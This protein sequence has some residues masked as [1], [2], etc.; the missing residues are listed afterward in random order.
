MTRLT[1]VLAAAFAAAL[2]VGCERAELSGPPELKLGRHECA[3]CGM[4]IQEDRFSCA[5]LVGRAG[6]RE[7]LLFDDVSCM[8]DLEREA[9]E[10]LG[11]IRRFVRDHGTREWT[12]AAAATFLL[13]DRER[14]L[15]PMGSGIASLAARSDAE[16]MQSQF[17][18][19]LLDYESLAAAR[20]KWMEERYGRPAR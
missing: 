15:T 13:T 9:A 8:L 6:R 10:S 14:L 16:R 11:V 1:I 12:D 20:K 5:V 18:G 17:G 19:E 4:I 2:S 7:H 3:E